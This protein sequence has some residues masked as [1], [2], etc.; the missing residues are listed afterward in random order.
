LNG[1]AV[2]SSSPPDR[3]QLEKKRTASSKEKTRSMKKLP[4][5]RHGPPNLTAL[6]IKAGG[7]RA[8]QVPCLFC[9]SSKPAT[10]LD[11]QDTHTRTCTNEQTPEEDLRRVTTTDVAPSGSRENWPR[12]ASCVQLRSRRGERR[13]AADV[14]A[15]RYQET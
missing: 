9:S 14:L 2:R 3:S 1:K 5:N 10:R 7:G 8:Q 13:P 4:E 11:T 15:N 6:L 12:N